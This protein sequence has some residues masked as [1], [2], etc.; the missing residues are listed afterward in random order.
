VEVRDSRAPAWDKAKTIDEDWQQLRMEVYAAMIDSVDQNV[1]RLLD[2]LEELDI[3]DNTLVLFLSDNGGCA[4]T[5][6]GND[7]KQVPGPKEFYSHVGPGWATASNTPWR[8]YK[9]YC[10]EGGIATPLLARWPSTIKAGIQTNQVGHIIDFLPTF[11]DMAKAEYPEK[12]PQFGEKTLPLEGKTLLPIL[13]GEQREPHDELYWHWAGNRAVRAGDWKL[14]W[15][16]REK[17]WA[18]YDMV[19]DRTEAH[20]LASENPKLVESLSAKWKAWAK[21]T[22][23]R[24]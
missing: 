1:G 24:Y 17:S 23:V 6:G 15:G 4:E 13:A 5:P 12:H 2:L 21:M 9:A 3:A 8:R 20:D 14:V 10:H 7:P 16:A 19:K 11:L 22:D 18:L